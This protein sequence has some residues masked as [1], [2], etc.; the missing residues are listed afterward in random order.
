MNALGSTDERITFRTPT[1]PW[2]TVGQVGA[3]LAAGMG[4]G[5][6]VYTPVLPL[7]EAQA[8]LTPSAGAALATANYFGYLIGALAGIA[9]PGL[10]R[11][12]ATLRVSLLVLTFTLALM[13]VASNETDWG[14]LRFIAGVTSALVFVFAVGAMHS[15]L[16]GQA[17]HLSGWA[18]GG[19][20]A[21]IALSGLVVLIL[22]SMSTW[23]SVWWAAALLTAICTLAAWTLTPQHPAS[24]SAD[25][26]RRPPEQGA[27]RFGALFASYSLEGVGYI[28]A[29]TFLV[30]AID[31]TAG[32]IAGSGAW[33]LVGL[34]ALPSGPLWASLGRRWS[35]PVLLVIAL[36][37]QAA[38]IAL[39]AVAGGIGPALVSAFLFG[40][41]FLG[42]SQMSLAIGAHLQ[43]PRAVAILTSGY[44][45]GQIAGPL[46]VTPLLSD[47]YHVALLVAAGIVLAA[48]LA[49]AG[50]SVRSR[51]TPRSG[52]GKAAHS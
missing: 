43:F 39:P 4:I 19:I 16:S 51:G 3:A 50:L 1:S 14:V 9:L 6:F 44:S 45:L 33:V 28:I 26:R 24:A 48:A 18:F 10:M 15:H 27:R 22:R 7:M 11:S 52:R 34:A 21:G 42:I 35:R 38:G 49:A 47:G 20:G 12:A 2:I 37:V 13:P 23:E 5:R 30:A 41:T 40:G 17:A 46:V 36:T 29:G 32:G 8:G 25:E 31:R